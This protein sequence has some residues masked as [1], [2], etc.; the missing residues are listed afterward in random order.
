MGIFDKLN[1]VAKK[2]TKLTETYTQ[3]AQEAISGTVNSK[4]QQDTQ[5]NMYIPHTYSL[6]ESIPNGSDDQEQWESVVGTKKRFSLAGKALEISENLDTFNSYRLM[7]KDLS[8]KYTDKAEKEYSDK[9]HDFIT[10]IELFPQIYDTNI[11]PIMKRAMDI[12]I[13]ND[14]WTLNLESFSLQHKSNFH[15]AIENYEVIANSANLT[16]EANQQMTSNIMS[17]ATGL[18]GDKYSG[19]TLSANIF[20]S[21]KEKAEKQALNNTGI[22]PEQQLELY[23][24]I[25]PQQLTKCIFADYWSVFISLIRT[26]NQNGQT[27]WLPTD[28]L[29][30]ASKTIFQNLSNPNFPKEKVLDAFIGVLSSN[31]YN[32]DYYKFMISY[33]GESEETTAIQNYFGYTDFND[34]RIS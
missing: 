8:N 5:Q 33:F 14:I 34:P 6:L 1:D 20:N 30:K 29:T 21:A 13:V 22:S 32:A 17:F 12:L 25:N 4:K 31:P 11:Y 26:L 2:A 23:Q 28:E 3:K 19:N 15:L 16:L 24:R 27:I 9:I 7:F 10:F 18:L